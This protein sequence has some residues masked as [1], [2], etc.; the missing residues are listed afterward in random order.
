MLYARTFE[1]RTNTQ[2]FQTFPFTYLIKDAK[3]S[4]T[5]GIYHLR[6][7]TN[8]IALRN[9]NY[10]PPKS[11]GARRSACGAPRVPWCA[12]V[13]QRADTTPLPQPRNSPGDDWRLAGGR[14]RSHRCGD[15]VPTGTP[16]GWKRAPGPFTAK[17]R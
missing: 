2:G 17:R 15:P 11:H 7:K 4:R 9:K 3:N 16:P 5:F 14:V 13:S 6:P 1:M 10:T 8:E 12:A